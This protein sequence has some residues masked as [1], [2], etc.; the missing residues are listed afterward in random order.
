MSLPEMKVLIEHRRGAYNQICLH[1]LS[2]KIVSIHGARISVILTHE[3][4]FIVKAN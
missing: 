1:S 3:V 4:V 2:G